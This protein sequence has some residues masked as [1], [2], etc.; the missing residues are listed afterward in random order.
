M[1]NSIK[2]MRSKNDPEKLMELYS[3]S[4]ALKKQILERLSELQDYDRLL[5]IARKD[6]SMRITIIEK[7]MASEHLT[8]ELIEYILSWL[9]FSLLH[10]NLLIYLES[11]FTLSQIKTVIKSRNLS[12]AVKRKLKKLIG[13]DPNKKDEE[14]P[15]NEDY[16]KLTMLLEEAEFVDIE[17]ISDE[18]YSDSESWEIEH[19]ETFLKLREEMKPEEDYG[20]L[21]REIKE[22]K[23]LSEHKPDFI[24]SLL[25]LS[26]ISEEDKCRLIIEVN[27]PQLLNPR[28]FQLMFNLVGLPVKFYQDFI[29]LT[30]QEQWINN[31]CRNHYV[32][33]LYNLY[34]IN[35][36]FFWLKSYFSC[37]ERIG[38][39]EP[40]HYKNAY[41]LSYTYGYRLMDLVP[42]K[43]LLAKLE[44]TCKKIKDFVSRNL[45][46]INDDL[47]LFLEPLL[48]VGGIDNLKFVLKLLE[49][50]VVENHAESIEEIENN[51]ID[52]KTRINNPKELNQL[53]M[54]E[55]AEKEHLISR[56]NYLAVANLIFC[57]L[58]S[59]SHVPEK[60]R[61]LLVEN[62][63]DLKKFLQMNDTAEAHIH[64]CRFIR[65]LKLTDKSNLLKKML[66]SDNYEVSIN[67]AVALV[68]L[69][70]KTV[71]KKLNSFANSPNY[72][73]RCK[74]ASVLKM[75]NESL[76]RDL[77]LKMAQDK[78]WEVSRAAIQSITQLPFAR[79]MQYLARLTPITYYKNLS[80]L[81]EALGDMQDI[82]VLPLLAEI[83]RHGTFEDY[84]AVIRALSKIPHKLSVSFLQALDL[85][86]NH[87]LEVE[88]CK[89]LIQLGQHNARLNLNRYLDFNVPV[90]AEK[91]KIAYLKLSTGENLHRIRQLTYDENPLVATLA[92]GKLFVY[93]E[94]EGWE[95]I[96]RLSNLYS[97]GIRA[98]TV[99]LLAHLPYRKIN[100]K[101]KEMH[102]SMGHPAKVIAALIFKQNGVDKYFDTLMRS[103]DSMPDELLHK[104]IRGIGQYPVV[105]SLPLLEKIILLQTEELIT[106]ACKVMKRVD[107][108][109]TVGYVIRLWSQVQPEL[110]TQLAG[111]LGH[112]RDSR[113]LPFINDNDHD[114]CE[115]TQVELAYAR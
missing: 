12:E 104:V 23:K 29:S 43:K 16:L 87:N 108:E 50:R 101:L 84:Y 94:K 56:D 44:E 69:G 33:D 20:Y 46:Q 24:L 74:F 76:E 13:E 49:H 1:L 34:K 61:N 75:M 31:F 48:V 100:H 4:P 18:E 8:L 91:A 45:H 96:D 60:T 3:S 17:A 80:F 109:E 53:V 21:I 36:S 14:R 55:I 89:S 25:N 28:Y 113:I 26:R 71:Q 107:S 78:H 88:R 51:Y 35:Q 64:V 15:E 77:S 10:K 65:L 93:S 41:K 19:L 6:L 98:N 57:N 7:L 72:V 68:N 85:K 112:F 106:S 27:V 5:Q 95:S 110:R 99:H 90:M 2:W 62:I 59:A 58:T 103:I 82:H 47:S 83:I 115:V 97:K 81:A 92:A 39:L 63:I 111:I 114:T 86:G 38:E 105:E 79:A 102:D 66:N 67:A 52:L 30:S 22:W 11:H 9:N 37:L 54:N 73:I 42:D 32:A 70:D 40:H